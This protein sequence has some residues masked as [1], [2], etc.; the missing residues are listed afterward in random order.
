MANKKEKVAIL[1]PKN[2][3]AKQKLGYHG[4]KWYVRGE[5]N[6]L[7]LVR[8]QKE[9]YVLRSRDGTK[10]L[11]VQKQNDPYFKVRVL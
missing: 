5:V 1:E 3:E 7:R 4:S 6:G 8:T 10:I 9:S 2:E 11:F